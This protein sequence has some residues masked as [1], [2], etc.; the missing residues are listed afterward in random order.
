MDSCDAV[1][2]FLFVKKSKMVVALMRV[3]EIFDAHT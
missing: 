2:I 1:K 3:A